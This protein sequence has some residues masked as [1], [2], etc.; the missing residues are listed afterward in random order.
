MPA[1]GEKQE[2]ISERGSH[3]FGWGDFQ[4]LFVA[5][6]PRS[7]CLQG[8]RMPTRGSCFLMQPCIPLL[9]MHRRLGNCVSGVVVT[10]AHDKLLVCSESTGT[11]VQRTR[12]AARAYRLLRCQLLLIAVFQNVWFF[13][14][15]VYRTLA[16]PR[17]HGVLRAANFGQCVVIVTNRAGDYLKDHETKA[18]IA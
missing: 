12:R 10:C 18:V 7:L 11:R 6:A 1:G 14:P 8:A 5:T 15:R 2:V 16:K 3:H 13:V 17:G 4:G 9:Q